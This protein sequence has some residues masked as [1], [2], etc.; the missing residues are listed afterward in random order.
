MADIPPA[1][2]AA[3]KAEENEILE[4]M[5][6]LKEELKPLVQNEVEN[7]FDNVCVSLWESDLMDNGELESKLDEYVELLDVLDDNEADFDDDFEDE[8]D[9]DDGL[10]KV[11]IC[12][13]PAGKNP[14]EVLEKLFKDVIM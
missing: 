1:E 2:D 6:A 5:E 9:S 11:A 4:R 14:E 10:C 8:D 12:A 7:N 3:K 13:V